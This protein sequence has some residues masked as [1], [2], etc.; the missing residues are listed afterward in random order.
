MSKTFWTACES[1]II[2]K[3]VQ[4]YGSQREAAKALKVNQVTVSRKVKKHSF[5]KNN[6]V[7]HK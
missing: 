2:E 5:F 1:M 7:L 3:A 4:K 6:V